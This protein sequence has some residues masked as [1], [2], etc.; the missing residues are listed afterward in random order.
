M[1]S[2]SDDFAIRQTLYRD[3]LTVMEAMSTK[4]THRTQECVRWADRTLC[5]SGSTPFFEERLTADAAGDS[6][7]SIEI[8]DDR[9]RFFDH[10]YREDAARVIAHN[11]EGLPLVNLF[12]TGADSQSLSS[13]GY[14]QQEMDGFVADVLGLAVNSGMKVHELR[15]GGQG[16]VQL[17]AARAALMY[18][19][20]ASVLC[21]KGFLF[22]DEKGRPHWNREDFLSRFDGVEP[23]PLPQKAFDPGAA[24][25]RA[26]GEGRATNPAF[27]MAQNHSVPGLFI[28]DILAAPYQ[29]V[30]ASAEGFAFF[31]P[32]RS[33]QKN[34]HC[35]P[36]EVS[37]L[38]LGVIDYLLHSDH[39]DAGALRAALPQDPNTLGSSAIASALSLAGIYTDHLLEARDI[40]RKGASALGLKGEEARLAEAC[41]MAVFMAAHGRDR[42]EI[43]FAMEE[44]Y[45]I[46]LRAAIGGLR[47]SEMISEGKS[48]KE[49][50]SEL[51]QMYGIL[52][53]RDQDAKVTS[54]PIWEDSPQRY[55]LDEILPRTSQTRTESFTVNGQQFSYEVPTGRPSH[56]V[57]DTL[58]IA[59]AAF[60]SSFSVEEAIR[61]SILVGGD[62]PSIA[63][64]A[65]AVSAAY[66]GGV[67]EQL[68]KRCLWTMDEKD[69]QVLHRFTHPSPV[70]ALK[71]IVPPDV[72]L[73][74][75]YTIRGQKY[76]RKQTMRGEVASALW[77]AGV[78]MVHD[79]E[80]R[81][82]IKEAKSFRE[83]TPFDFDD[84]YRRSLYATPDGLVSATHVD[85]PGM[86]SLEQREKSRAVFEEFA[87]HCEE[88][89]D[90]MEM[91]FGYSTHDGAQEHLRFTTACFPS[92]H[93][94]TIYLYDHSILDGSV[95]LDPRTGLVKVNFAGDLREGEYRDADWCR[96][97]VLDSRRIVTYSLDEGVPSGWLRE[98]GAE[99]LSYGREEEISLRHLQKGSEQYTM[100]LDGLKEAVDRACLDYG[101][102]E[103][104]GRESNIARLHADYISMSREAEHALS[105]IKEDIGEEITSCKGLRI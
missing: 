93:G 103:S 60:L 2:S 56:N 91:V 44:D 82:L 67:P 35:A 48:M 30:D 22:S 6:L 33:H 99:G 90:R 84:G 32:A 36:T 19:I 37:R 98:A 26:Q 64:M 43:R 23:T 40:S 50:S 11:T 5:F 79:K 101:I 14:T 13:L 87:R 57:R 31:S 38:G 77:K 59:L 29:E 76:T 66:Y 92:R 102:T 68:S 24:L 39:S 83:N 21:P 88:V 104:D 95:E 96:E 94:D 18:G 8:P 20:P 46:D 34:Y 62:S 58:P 16:G 47:A 78:Q 25:A 70:Q 71:V 7:L 100:D 41:T 65:G 54:E 51:L 73:V 12:V 89:R 17:S 27:T 61:R 52:L 80:L 10:H 53:V 105:A 75:I 86:P 85:L 4:Y 49:I 97:H 63:A 1:S 28:G 45:G 42:S 9:Q 81:G 3:G 69:R 55:T 74:D 72:M 15:S